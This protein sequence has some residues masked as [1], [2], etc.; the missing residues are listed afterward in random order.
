MIYS[1]IQS[2]YH[3]NLGRE[4]SAINRERAL[5]ELGVGGKIL[6][7]NYDPNEYYDTQKFLLDHDTDVINMYDYFQGVSGIPEN[8]WQA[9]NLR[10]APNIDLKQNL[11]NV[12]SDGT[13]EYYDH[14]ILKMKAYPLPN[15]Y[16]LLGSV[17]YYDYTG[18]I[19]KTD[20][21]DWRGF[22]SSIKYYNQEGKLLQQK[23]LN[24]NGDV[25]LDVQAM[26]KDNQVQ[27]TYY[28]LHNYRGQNYL[29]DSEQSLFAFFV[30]MVVSEKK[31]KII[32]DD[33]ELAHKLSEV[34]S[35]G[36]DKLL[37]IHYN[38]LNYT[39]QR[40]DNSY[41]KFL[42]DDAPYYSGVIVAT[43]NQAQDL[44]TKI[45]ADE[46]TVRVLPDN[47][48]MDDVLKMPLHSRD[49][50]KP[51][52]I[53]YFGDLTTVA[54]DFKSFI[55]VC[56]AIKKQSTKEVHFNIYT[57]YSQIN[58]LNKLMKDNGLT[59][60]DMTFYDS[61]V[62]YRFNNEVQNNIDIVIDTSISDGGSMMA[63]TALGFGKPIVAYQA[64]WGNNYY[65]QNNKNAL[66]SVVGNQEHFIQQALKLI[67]DPSLCNQL[68]QKSKSEAKNKLS[69][70]S[71]KNDLRKAKLI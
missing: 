41:A 42:S 31:G 57:N 15:S 33:I 11:V 43:P 63:T 6:T 14:D 28:K 2:I 71:F 38:H 24:L 59:A 12:N 53:G 66:L 1:V 47:V 21:Y 69:V 61:Q 65:L 39:A 35:L 44:R 10:E 49:K 54:R 5:K 20:M 60:D 64:N 8:P 45:N 3:F 30:Q 9:V 67:N 50:N 40:I 29:F 18:H 26:N 27:T 62:S 36:E 17:D 48:I 34:N 52:Q 37:Y 25:V 7:K 51:V 23:F 68:S 55:Q 46:S 16:S 13:I 19:V 58:N 22:K 70:S 4:Y 32:V 56:A